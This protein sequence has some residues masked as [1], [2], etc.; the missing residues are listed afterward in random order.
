MIPEEHPSWFV[1][2]SSKIEDY[3]KCPRYFFYHHILG[4]RKEEESKDLI[5]GEAWHLAQEMLLKKG[6]NQDAI[7][8]GYLLAE[9]CY[10]EAF[11]NPETDIQRIPKVPAAIF[12]AL[13][14]YIEQY[15][16]DD[17]EV[18]HTE[19]TG[20]V[21]IASNKI[22]RFKMDSVLFDKNKGHLSRD[23][24]TGSQN[25]STW[26]EGF[27]MKFQFG[28]YQHVLH[29]LY[30]DVWGIEVNGAVFTKTKGVE[31]VR[32]PVRRTVEMMEVWLHLANYYYDRIQSDVNMIRQSLEEDKVMPCFIMSTTNC[33]IYSGCAFMDFCQSWPNPL[34]QDLTNPPEGFRVEF[35]NPIELEEKSK[36]VMHL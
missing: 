28:T 15:K 33:A 11:P 8:E 21:P 25:S 1:L 23:H 29:C 34:N 31:Y 10:R 4:W 7:N 24:K 14:K 22:L 26:R 16:D 5:F 9:A 3:I 19:I 17:E 18:L 13:P 35:W 27:K 30:K 2:D 36:N 32:I 6:Y 12:A 20:S